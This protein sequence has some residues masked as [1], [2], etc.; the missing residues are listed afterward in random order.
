MKLVYFSGATNNT[1][2]FV[3]KLG[4]VAQ[5]SVRIPLTATAEPLLVTEPYILITSTYGG[6]GRA[7]QRDAVPKQVIKF[8]NVPE[9]RALLRGVIAT[10]NMNFGR[11]YAL[12][13]EIISRKCG[14]P[15]LHTLEILGT[16]EDVEMVTSIIESL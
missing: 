6:G 10:G 2:R 15:V 11:T 12:A 1:H 13:G 3:A 4:D 14:V 8:L 9:N 16:P 7:E 5:D